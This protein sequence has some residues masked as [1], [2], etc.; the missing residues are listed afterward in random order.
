MPVGATQ[1]VSANIGDFLYYIDPSTGNIE[2][3]VAL[4]Q[5]CQCMIMAAAAISRTA[6]HAFPGFS[7]S[8]RPE[9]TRLQ[10]GL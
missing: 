7:I 10:A 2:G 6:Q 4:T 8:T 5:N 3:R 1:S 9:P